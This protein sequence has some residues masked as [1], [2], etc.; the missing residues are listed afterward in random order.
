[1]TSPSYFLRYLLASFLTVGLFMSLHQSADAQ[2][3]II[4]DG[5]IETCSGTFF[6]DGNNPTTGEGGPYTAGNNYTFTICPDTPGDVI[7][8]EFPAFALYQSPNPNNSD[9]LT[10]YDGDDA[11]ATSLGS[12]T[13]DGLQGLPITATINNP[14]GCLTFVF[15]S[16]PNG[17]GEFP[18]WEGVISCTTPCDPPTAQYE[19]VNPLPDE[20]TQTIGVC[21]GD[22][23][24]FGDAGSTAGAGFNLVEYIWKFDDGTADTL[25]GPE[26][27]THAF[28]EPGEYLVNLV[29]VDNNGCQSL[30]LSPLQVLVSTIPVFNTDFESTICLG[31]PAQLNGNPVQSVTWTA[32]PPQVVAG[33]TY[34]PDG[35]GFSYSST[36]TF[37]FF[38]TGATLENCD[39]LVSVVANMEHSY[40]GD[41]GIT[42]SCPDGTT[43]EL[44]EH[45]NSGGGTYL[46]EAVDDGSNVA[47]TGY[48]YGWSPSSTN[49]FIDDNE[50][51][52]N[53]AYVDN[54]GNDEPNASI[55]NPGIYE[56]FEDM[57]N[58]VGCPL[59]G[60]WSFT[61]TDNYGIDNGY[62]FSWG[63]NFD[64][65]L[66]PDITTFTP[67]VG[68]GPDS[69][70]WEGPHITNTS[71]N[72]N[73]IDIAPPAVGNY[74]YTFTAM[75]NF[76]CAFDTTVT[77][78]V[79]EGPEITAGP[80]LFVCN[81]PVTLEAGIADYEGECGDDAGTYTYC[82][83]NG[84]PLTVTYCPD[85][86]NDGVTFMEFTIISGTTE[87]CCDEFYVYDG[88]DTNAPLLAG[89]MAGDLSGL[90]FGATNPS[91]CI[92]FMI[93]P[94][95]SIS[96]DS[97]SE[98][99]LVISVNCLG[100]ANLVWSWSPTTGLSDPNI[101]NPT[102]L[103]DQA[104][105]YTVTA[106]PAEFPGCVKTDQ[107]VVSPDVDADPG[108]DA[109]TTICYNSPASLLTDYLYGTP[110]QGGEWTVTG[111]GDPFGDD[112]ITPTDYTEGATFNLTYTVTN[113]VCTNSSNLNLT[114]LGVTDQSCCQTNAN[115]GPDAIACALTYQLQAEPVIGQG[116]WTGPE[117]V[118]FSDIHDPH[119]TVTAE[120]PGGEI[121]LTWTD[122]NGFLCSVSNDITITFADSLDIA[123]VTED[124]VCFD[125]CSGTAI[126][127]PSGGTAPSGMYSYEWSGGTVG[128]TSQ[129]RDSLC[130]GIHTLKVTDNV[131]CTDST[132]FTI[133]Q[134]A[135][136]I[137][138]V[139]Q[140]APLCADSCNA[141]VVVD[142]P[143][144]VRYSFDNGQTWTPDSVGYKCAGIDTVI[145]ENAAGCQITKGIELTDPPR[146][147]AA[148]NI[149]PN[150]TT[151][152]NT[153]VTFQD[154]STP[155]PI[156]H[157]LFEF[158]A[159]YKIGTA[160]ER[161]STFQFPRDTSG[162]YTVRLIS[163]SING[164]IDTLSKELV[165]KDELM[166]FIPN[167]FTPNGD[168]INDVWKPVGFTVD[169]LDYQITIYDRW[170][171]QVFHTTDI[172]QGWRGNRQGTEY[173]VPMGV[174]SY[175]MEITSATTKEKR[176]VTGFITLTR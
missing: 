45:P 13:G 167:S 113:G 174:Y 140:S 147:T 67:I 137:M 117:N 150:P 52:F 76:G 139:I 44:L 148:F 37:D 43:V 33:E 92:T 49:G 11:T 39:D 115:P 156:R 169:P 77:V 111:T 57:C 133:G 138:N 161:L 32:L 122:D 126:A 14:T 163:E 146:F 80:D 19:F 62:I 170:G 98:E 36:L 88:E 154:V 35:S 17:T 153:V 78:E 7:Q 50:N 172:H 29:V 93:D 27:V 41:L 40:L 159:D 176:T 63:I 125:E 120:A 151:T 69:T 81:E 59:N 55:V 87:D 141:R 114:I 12:Y 70:Y 95:F 173:F 157:S 112:Q 166:W 152:E 110:V 142:A 46:G 119:A 82:Y 47:G 3:F 108:I 158:F 60:E 64:P 61:V 97:G 165:I 83:E 34:L 164:C 121:T 24:T 20:G 136:Q 100:G 51:S 104:T 18:G 132:T 175:L 79:I 21:L 16:N 72:G 129:I 149:N 99:E 171:S 66:F 56:S 74:D 105:V 135:Q 143:E 68:L 1:M 160:Q 118:S 102:V 162:T 131:G 23:I 4:E 22:P 89:P 106:Y 38:E 84:N 53:H 155:G 31:S 127:I 128:G 28:T 71:D 42:I 26:D 5:S 8:V 65:S 101:Q 130:A 25:N 94:D 107:V 85:N 96:C 9:Y 73:L 144:A 90:S 2:V 30:N 123:A 134:P 103:V 48:D 58:L 145:A 91:G 116:T 15:T 6:D 10:V 75:N 168:G 109:D 124:A 54:N 86:P